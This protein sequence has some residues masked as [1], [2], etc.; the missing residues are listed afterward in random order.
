MTTTT[1]LTVVSG[2]LAMICNDACASKQLAV[3]R[4]P[5]PNELWFQCVS[6]LKLGPESS[7]LD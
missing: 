3:T 5:H 4:V 2:T 6:P 7:P 1:A